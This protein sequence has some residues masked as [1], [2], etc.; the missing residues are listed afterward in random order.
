LLYRLFGASAV[1]IVRRIPVATA[2]AVLF[3]WS[4]VVLGL[5]SI[6]ERAPTH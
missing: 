3:G 5:I 1:L 6:R 2:V 4:S